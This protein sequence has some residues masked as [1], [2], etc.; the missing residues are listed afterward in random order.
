MEIAMKS[1][2]D[3]YA[4]ERAK[5]RVRE[6]R[7]FYI[8]LTCYCLVMPVLIFINLR[9]TPEYYWFPFSMGGWGIGLLFHGLTAFDK[10]PFFNR[11]WEE[12]KMREL[13]ENEKQRQQ[14]LKKFA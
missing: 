2:E 14:T 12:R 6:I 11:D 9:Y 10:V 3:K 13:M 8:N 4:Y 1:F 5:K 7:S